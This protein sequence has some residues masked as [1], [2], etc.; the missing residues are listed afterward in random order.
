MNFQC[1][2]GPSVTQDCPG[3]TLCEPACILPPAYM[4]SIQTGYEELSLEELD[5]LQQKIN[6]I[7]SSYKRANVSNCGVIT[8]FSSFQILRLRILAFSFSSAGEC[9]YGFVFQPAKLVSVSSSPERC[10]GCD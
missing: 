6:N 5:H 1:V 10:F 4:S 3:G 2:S 8:Y 9:S 7:K